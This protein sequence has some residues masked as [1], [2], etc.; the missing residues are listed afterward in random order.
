MQP[1]CFSC[2]S[3]LLTLALSLALACSDVA[4]GIDGGG[5]AADADVHDTQATADAS[6]DASTDVGDLGVADTG[7]T[8][9]YTLQVVIGTRH[10]TLD[11]E[12]FVPADVSG[13][14]VEVS[15]IDDRPPVI[16]HYAANG[17]IV[18]A[19]VA[20]GLRLV[21]VDRPGL[22]PELFIGTSTRVELISTVL[23]RAGAGPTS[24]T[25]LD[26]TLELASPWANTDGLELRSPG[27]GFFGGRGFAMVSEGATT[28]T[29]V[30]GRWPVDRPLPRG[31]ADDDLYVFRFA[32]DQLQD[33]ER[34][35]LAE[36]GRIEDLSVADGARHSQTAAL[37]PASVDLAVDVTWDQSALL[38]LGPFDPVPTG[39]PSTFDAVVWSVGAD[40]HGLYGAGVNVVLDFA[41]GQPVR[42]SRL[43]TAAPPKGWAAHLA[44][45]ISI[46]VALPLPAGGILRANVGASTNLAVNDV[47]LD[48]RVPVALTW[49]KALSIDGVASWQL[50]ALRNLSV[51]PTLAWAA[52]DLG[53][54]RSYAVVLH[55]VEVA[56]SPR[57]AVLGTI[58]TDRPEVRVPDGWLR[59]GALYFFQV[60]ASDTV[61]FDRTPYRFASRE[62]RSTMVS[63]V[64]SVAR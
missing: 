1:R 14:R 7:D 6:L 44:S 51:T 8:E 43:V 5:L 31:A 36:L 24:T 34:F 64:F 53:T 28:V 39:E 37:R 4:T 32:Y 58:Y 33:R 50:E 60:V 9:R 62:S 57:A 46:S 41:D 10:V 22:S 18:V 56:D 47:P 38:P 11:G 27:T 16:G 2:C 26:I 15:S 61:E 17:L 59:P 40:R 30:G 3:Q 48:H 25:T 45:S 12:E 21:R 49:A 63:N 35:A 23:G 55:E 20:P 29:G 52:P 54:A 19:G 13:A 42:S